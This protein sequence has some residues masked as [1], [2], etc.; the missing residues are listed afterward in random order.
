MVA[1]IGVEPIIA[2]F[3]ADVMSVVSVPRLVPANFGGISRI[4]TEKLRLSGDYHIISMGFYQL[5]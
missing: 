4:R 2:F 1:E 3:N 5:N